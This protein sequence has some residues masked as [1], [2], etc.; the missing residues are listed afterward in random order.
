MRVQAARLSRHGL[1]LWMLLCGYA[2]AWAADRAKL[3]SP[4]SPQAASPSLDA[5]GQLVAF[6]IPAQPL[7]S[8]LDQYAAVSGRPALFRSTLVAGR[9]SS[10][11]H[12]RYTAQAALLLLLKGTGLVAS[13]MGAGQVDAFVLKPESAAAAMSVRR[14]GADSGAVYDGLVQA[15]VWKAFCGNPQTVPGD[16]RSLLRFQVDASGRIS[17]VRLIG[18]SGDKRRDAALLETLGRIQIE[19]AP[20]PDMAQPMTMLILPRGQIA[21]QTCDTGAP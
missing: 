4:S 20:P 16:Y 7:V 2:P 10:P 13:E 8:A 21:G 19:Q 17:R 11:V 3:P 12:G 1:A 6:D 14:P 9:T 15:R 5:A 18:S